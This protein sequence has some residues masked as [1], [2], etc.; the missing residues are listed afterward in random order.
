MSNRFSEVVFLGLCLTTSL[1]AQSLSTRELLTLTKACLPAA[2][3]LTVLAIVQTESSRNTLALSLNYPQTLAR[4]LGLPP[5][6]VYLKHQPRS[7]GEAI[8]W[9]YDLQRQGK[10]V[11]VGLMQVSLEHLPV[12]AETA[13]QPCD[14]LK[15]G[16]SIFV[17]KYNLGVRR[18][19]PGQAAL[20]WA[21][22]AYNGFG[23]DYL[24][25][26]LL[27]WGR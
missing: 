9:A 10:T 1:S 17:D 7:R 18:L 15:L 23:S 20:R 8:R 11:S 16:W 14:N 4:Q 6:R 27:N 22:S 24:S 2:D 3:P 12:P 21:I 13:I 5:G 26:V 25:Q 19:G